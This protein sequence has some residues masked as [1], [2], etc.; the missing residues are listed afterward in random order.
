MAAS[1]NLS[2][3]RPGQATKSQGGRAP[4]APMV[5]SGAKVPSEQDPGL[6][7]ML[8]KAHEFFQICDIEDKGFITRREMQRL[9]GELPLSLEELEK[10]FDTLDADGNGSLSLEEFTTGFSQFLFGEK[11]PLNEAC[12]EHTKQLQFESVYQSKWEESVHKDEDE[13]LQFYNLVDSLGANRFLEDETHIKKLWKQLQ[14]DEPHLLPNFE[15]LLA[16]IFSQL[17]EANTEK[18]EIENALKKKIA[19]YD[20]EM[21]NLYEEMEQQ[22]KKEKEEFLLQDT[23]KF[24]S[25]SQDLEEKL[26]SKEQELEHL[27]QKQKKVE[28]QC[29]ELS[30]DK[31][32]TK[33]ENE[34]LKMR[35]S[36]MRRDLDRTSQ[37]LLTAQQQLRVLQ[38]EASQLHEAREME[39]YRVTESSQREKTMLQKQLNLLREMNKHLRDEHDGCLQKSRASSKNSFRNQRSG[40]VIGNYI[41]RKS[42]MKSQ[43][44]EDDE[45]FSKVKKNNS[46][47][48][49]GSCA[50]AS[51]TEADSNLE[52]GLSPNHHLQRIISIEEDD[53]PQHLDIQQER[54]LNNWVEEPEDHEKNY[55]TE[56][57][58]S[59]PRGQPVGKETWTNE[60]RLHYAPDRLFK[61]IFV[62]N[63]SVGKT[64]F[65]RRFCEDSFYSGTSATVGID[66]SVKTEIVDNCQ[67]A[68]QLWDTA[69]QERYRS[70]TKQFFRKADGVIVMYDI[71]SKPTFM[72]VR[73][74]LVSVEEG[75]GGTLPLLL[76]GNKT[77]IE[78]EREVPHGLGEQLAKDCNL[79][80]YECSAC[81]G[82]NAKE[83]VLHLARVLKEQ[84]DKEKEKTIQLLQD[85]KKKSCCSRQ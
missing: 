83:S 50:P 84:E 56:D 77:D 12:E 37:E 22:I 7:A 62:G 17:H 49:N 71:T 11:I 34:K 78:K 3:A 24:Q 75:A 5:E 73:Q 72:A 32:E 74:W 41:D 33:V 16:R 42:S 40:S 2:M 6:L 67:V 30:N 64:S 47:G 53:F 35:N 19:T 46:I 81:T 44:S 4:P 10:V 1:E 80:F 68:L 23:E 57:T 85:S 18:T 51:P 39:V 14:K 54:S 21:Q 36:E 43:S 13:D 65:L 82:H 45:V 55:Q 8:G 15:E 9:H 60:E 27:I 25:R 29:M 52:G 76:L 58:P 59:S 26:L 66:Y 20:E 63:S 61:I 48:E 70:I 31:Q 28:K 38:E 79:I 69:G